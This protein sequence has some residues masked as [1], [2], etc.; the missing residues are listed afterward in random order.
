[1]DKYLEKI[2][3]L[4]I[5]FINRKETKRYVETRSRVKIFTG[6]MDEFKSN[7]RVTEKIAVEDLQVT[8]TDPKAVEIFL[9]KHNLEL[10]GL[11]KPAPIKFDGTGNPVEQVR[12]P[13][14]IE[15]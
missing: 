8:V 12:A 11:G 6:D 1:L 9:Q 2:P 14:F 7:F 3:G 13:Y 15:N 5:S 10:A 4:K